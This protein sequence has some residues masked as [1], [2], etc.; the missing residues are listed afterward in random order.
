[1]SRKTFKLQLIKI[2]RKVH[3]RQVF[4]VSKLKE[5]RQ[6]K[7][8]T[9]KLFTLSTSLSFSVTHVQTIYLINIYLFIVR[10]YTYIIHVRILAAAA[11]ATIEK[12][13]N[14]MPTNCITVWKIYNS[15]KQKK[16][17]CDDSWWLVLATRKVNA[18]VNI[19]VQQLK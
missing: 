14:F 15:Q 11:A 16:Y 5:N 18:F 7:G 19:V 1:M 2:E 9:F 8:R 13:K 3:H 12:K 17:I 4:G 6:K 10:S